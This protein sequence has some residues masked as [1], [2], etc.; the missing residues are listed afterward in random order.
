MPKTRKIPDGY[1][2][3]KTV[4]ERLDVSVVWATELIKRRGIQTYKYGITV[5]KNSD[6][7]K[8]QT[9]EPV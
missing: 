8:L 2:S 4:A 1:L 9:P 7:P 3:I 6:F 5:I